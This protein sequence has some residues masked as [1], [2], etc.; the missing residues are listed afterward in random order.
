MTY[1]EQALEHPQIGSDNPWED[2][3]RDFALHPLSEGVEYSGGIFQIDGNYAV[4][5]AD[6]SVLVWSD[7]RNSWGKSRFEI[8]DYFDTYF[9]NLSD[10][11]KEEIRAKCN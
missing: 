1:A 5:F 8:D 3:F 2:C 6:S 10:S 9:G 4:I 11:E 7:S